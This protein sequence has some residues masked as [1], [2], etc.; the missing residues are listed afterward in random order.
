MVNEVVDAGIANIGF[1]RNLNQVEQTAF[2]PLQNSLSLCQLSRSKDMNLWA[3]ESGQ[4][5][6]RQVGEQP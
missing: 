6:L 1:L 5:Y 3:L 4:I 2:V